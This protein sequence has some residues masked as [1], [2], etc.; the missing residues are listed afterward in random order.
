MSS[1]FKKVVYGGSIIGGS[2][3]AIP[4]ANAATTPNSIVT[5]QTPNRGIVQ[6]LQGT[7]TAGTY[8]TLYTAGVNGSRCYSLVSTN[9]E[10]SVVHSLTIQ[11]V[12]STTKF[13]GTN[14]VTVA[15]SGFTSTAAPQPIMTPAVWPGLPVDQYGNPY[16]QMVSGDTLQVTFGT[17]LSTGALIN[18]Y[19][20]CSDF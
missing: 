13:G 17:A 11:V 3:L 9:T 10:T 12:N 15:N 7:D 8:K 20:S 1:M 19:T 18:L 2:I 14:I 16:I 4:A 6:F 5:P